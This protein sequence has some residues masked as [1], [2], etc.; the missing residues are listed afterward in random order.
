MIGWTKER[1]E[2]GVFVTANQAVARS[3]V[4]ARLIPSW[5]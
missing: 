4:N 2:Y 5:H 3:R 1:E